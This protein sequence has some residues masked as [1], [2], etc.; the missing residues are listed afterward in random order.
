MPVPSTIDDLSTTAASN[1]PSGSDQR[2]QADDYLRAHA[3]IIKL[4]HDRRDGLAIEEFGAVGDGT[5]DDTTALTDAIAEAES[6]G[7]AVIR[8]RA[9]GT[10]RITDPIVLPDDVPV[11]IRGASKA[12]AGGL[13]S[14][15]SSVLY[16]D[17]TDGAAIRMQSENQVL[18]DLMIQGS[19]GR[20]AG[21]IN[22]IGVL[23]EAP[24]DAS[25]AARGCLLKRVT[26]RDHG[27]HAVVTSGNVNHTRFDQVTLRNIKGH[28]FMLDDGTVTSRV[29][30][31]RPGQI[32]LIDCRAF[33]VA[34]HQAKIGN[35]GGAGAYR[36]LV[37]NFETGA[38]S[39]DY[40][41]SGIISD[42]ASVWVQGENVR[43]TGSA[44]AGE[45]DGTPTL[46]GL[47]IGGRC[48]RVL[49]CRYISVLSPGVLIMQDGSYD[50]FDTIVDGMLIS[51]DVTLNPAV[52]IETGVLGT[53]IIAQNLDQISVVASGD[54]T[55]VYVLTRNLLKFYQSIE[56][57]TIKVPAAT[58][59]FPC[60]ATRA[61][62]AV[63]FR[64][65]R[66]GTGASEASIQAA[67]GGCLLTNG[68]N[69]VTIKDT[70]T[71]IGA[72]PTSA[73]GL[74]TGDLWNDSGTV[75]VA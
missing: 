26:V 15:A 10:Y 12:S 29:N 18:Q 72:L 22:Q 67:G 27:G 14:N 52:S 44:F 6:L 69:S 53:S 35:S 20:L 38:Y 70:T 73:S 63:G 60:E 71:N 65:V 54:L 31:E 61:N 57:L 48:N 17:H 50:T 39:T 36:I 74:S 47:A 11:S 5:T 66:T 45:K 68:T 19:A 24:D 9:G 3:A 42:N 62:S 7:G 2:S 32:S 59:Q 25:A 28:G 30:T 13:V 58:S 23:I 37:D 33:N 40:H 21:N 43:I 1:S 46:I 4:E 55:D 75:K 56:G 51:Q 8:L 64:A 49:A 16:I 34:G 41:N